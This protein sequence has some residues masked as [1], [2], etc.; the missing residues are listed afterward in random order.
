[1]DYSADGLL[2]DATSAFYLNSEKLNTP[3]GSG[4]AAFAA[5]TER[6]KILQNLGAG[7]AQSW[8]EVEKAF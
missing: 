2:I 4:Y 5:A 3:M 6:D 1:M 8:P 7:Q